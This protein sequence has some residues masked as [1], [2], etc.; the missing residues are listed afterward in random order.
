M[1]KSVD[2][3]KL[4]NVMT[5]MY[6][7][8]NGLIASAVEAAIEDVFDGADIDEAV[9]SEVDRTLIYN[10][11]IWTLLQSYQRPT[12]ANYDEM[13]DEFYDDVYRFTRDYIDLLDSDAEE[14]K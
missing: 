1:T 9:S 7:E 11:D 5:D 6:Y 13:V 3:R 12:E 14:E 8:A 2:R 10:E 4:L